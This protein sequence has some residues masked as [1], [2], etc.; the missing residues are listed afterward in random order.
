MRYKL[1]SGVDFVN[2]REHSQM[3]KSILISVPVL[4]IIG[5]FMHFLFDLTGKVPVIGAFVPVN[6]SPWEHLKMAFYPMLVWWI[7]YYLRV[8]KYENFSVG[9]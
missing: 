7:A 3:K 9:N 4:F 6:E 8:R 2:N 1:V 5:G